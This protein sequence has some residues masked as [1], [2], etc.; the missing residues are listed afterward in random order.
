MKLLLQ[1]LIKQ[2]SHLSLYKWLLLLFFLMLSLT[3][4]TAGLQ[5]SPTM[6]N[7]TERNTIELI[8]LSNTGTS[9]LRGQVRVYHWNQYMGNNQLVET[10]DIQVSP[11]VM[12]IP[13]G[14]TQW[15]RIVRK[16]PQNSIE[17]AYRLIVDELPSAD[18][19]TSPAGVQFLMQY[20]LPVFIS[21]IA[22]KNIPTALTELTFSINNK[23]GKS[24]LF[25]KNSRSTHLKLSQLT[26]VTVEGKVTI[27]QPGLLGYVLAG[28]SAQWE[29]PSPHSSGKYQAIINND[30]VRQTLLSYSN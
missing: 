24:Y 6:I 28:Q 10:K 14:E 16:A 22:Q 7:L 13:P 1:S 8:Y 20:S 19:V 29:I 3:A 12:D 15:V 30:R 2:V 9:L 27:L 25:V 26:Y 21:P 17:Q 11:P 4:N 23:Q 18:R 5:V